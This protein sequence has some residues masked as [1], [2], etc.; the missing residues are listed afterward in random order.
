M[1]LLAVAAPLHRLHHQVLRGHE[2]QV[3]PQRPVHHRLVDAQPC[4][5]VLAQPQH[6]VGAQKALR[7]GDAPVGGVVQRPLHPLDGGGH[8]GVHGV[9][10]QIAAQGADAFA[11]H[12]IALIGHGGR[13]DLAVLER[14][15]HLPVVLQQADVVGHAIGALGDTAE[16]VEDPAVHFP[17]I[18][19][20]AHGEALRKA[21]PGG[22]AAVHLVD[23]L[24]VAL[25]QVHKAG[26]G[27]GGAPA[28]QEFQSRQH[29][30]QLLHV[31][32]EVLHPQRGPLAHRHRLGRLIVGIAQRGGGGVPPGKIRQIHQHRQQ[33]CPQIPQ[34][35]PVQDQVGVVGDIA[36]GGAQMD[37][38]RR[39]GGGLAVGVDVSHDIVAHLSLPGRRRVVVDIGDM[40]LQLRHLLRRHR[41]AQLMLGTGQRR[42][43]PPPGLKAAVRRKQVQHVRRG[44][45]GRQRRTVYVI[46]HRYLSCYL[47]IRLSL[48]APTET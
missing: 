12:G 38:A 10:H 15:L 28:A 14:L 16:T 43:Q 3:L 22:N 1:E 36:A 20:A 32:E 18:G 26:L 27:A 34:A 17:G 41:Q 33:L 47:T 21:E 23:L 46:S 7:H 44:V 42:P 37:D 24:L 40:S 5:H 35:V 31:T 29:L 19:L 4:R 39:R 8:G 45:A 25:K 2:G 11:A 30:I 9:R 48:S 6:R 13:A